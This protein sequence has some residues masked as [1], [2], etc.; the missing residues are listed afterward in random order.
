MEWQQSRPRSKRGETRA[1][2]RRGGG[3]C[4]FGKQAM[5]I[6]GNKPA[7]GTSSPSVGLACNL[8]QPA[9][10]TTPGGAWRGPPSGGGSRSWHQS[11][12]SEGYPGIQCVGARWLAGTSQPVKVYAWLK[13]YPV[14]TLSSLHQL[15]SRPQSKPGTGKRRTI[16]PS[17]SCRWMDPCSLGALLN[18]LHQT[19]SSKE[20]EGNPTGIRRLS[21]L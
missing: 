16:H 11:R 13:L 3:V 2:V 15:C 4:V 21:Q 12:G 10:W 20:V 14:R 7:C 6:L 9:R 5:I 19:R 1:S 8:Q 17:P 18:R